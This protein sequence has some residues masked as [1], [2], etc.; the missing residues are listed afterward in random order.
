VQ[1]E[2]LSHTPDS[3]GHHH[4][5][6]VEKWK[7]FLSTDKGR[8]ALHTGQILKLKPPSAPQKNIVI[9]VRMQFELDKT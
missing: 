5:K 9:Y 2:M 6:E 8:V 4:K 1:I 7:I 3:H